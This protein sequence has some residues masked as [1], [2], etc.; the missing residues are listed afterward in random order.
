[1]VTVASDDA[2]ASCRSVDGQRSE[3]DHRWTQ[4]IPAVVT[5]GVTGDAELGAARATA[6]AFSACV[7]TRWWRRAGLGLLELVGGGGGVD[8][9]PRDR[10]VG[11][12]GDDVVADLG[13][14]AVDEVA[15]GRRRRSRVRSSP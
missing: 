3:D 14:S 13:E 7:R 15:V 6:L 12:D 5:D 1:M 8:L 11:Q 10:A 2:V 4:I 9:R